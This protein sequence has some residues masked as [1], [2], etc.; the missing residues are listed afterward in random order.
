MAVYGT[1]RHGGVGLRPMERRCARLGPGC[2]ARGSWLRARALCARI[3]TASTRRRR[4]C[5]PGS[6]RRHASQ[7]PAA[8]PRVPR[9]RA[10][11]SPRRGNRS[12][13]RPRG[14]R[15]AAAGRSYLGGVALK[16][17]A[18]SLGIVSNLLFFEPARFSSVLEFG[19]YETGE[20]FRVPR[21]RPSP[22]SPL[23]APP[24][25]LISPNLNDLCSQLPMGMLLT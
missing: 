4:R 2:G 11:G 13:G 22:R 8:H 10:R 14:Q 15:R 6:A 21:P 9:S 23:P 1:S 24:Y 5:T 3:A 25:V 19:T 17:P 18:R 16:S 7:S 12:M 20:R